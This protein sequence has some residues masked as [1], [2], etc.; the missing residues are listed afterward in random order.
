MCTLYVTGGAH[1]TEHC[2]EETKCHI[3]QSAQVHKRTWTPEYT[4]LMEPC[5]H[6]RVVPYIKREKKLGKGWVRDCG[7]K[8]GTLP[9]N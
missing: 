3:S 4:M 7:L 6:G 8:K 1:K 2:R 9:D 5:P